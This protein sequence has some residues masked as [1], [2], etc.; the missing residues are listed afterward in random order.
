[1]SKEILAMVKK[2]E[3]EAL[4]GVVKKFRER[5]ALVETAIQK[6]TILGE[7]GLQIIEN[8]KEF[9]TYQLFG[10][11]L[12]VDVKEFQTIKKAFGRLKKVN[13][14]PHWK[15]RRTVIVS[16]APTDENF[17]YVYFNYE[18]KLKKTDKCKIVRVT[19]KEV[20]CSID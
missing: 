18:Y 6:F 17:R 9:G 1:M 11:T 15:K 10:A 5:A 14:Q 7:R 20:Q 19:K 2:E 16:L 12:T 4:K 13:V 8:S 3:K